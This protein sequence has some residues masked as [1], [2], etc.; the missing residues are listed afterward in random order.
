MILF[1]LL[2]TGMALV[3]HPIRAEWLRY[4]GSICMLCALVYISQRQT[5][6]TTAYFQNCQTPEVIQAK[7]L[8]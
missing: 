2:I 1:H 4:L 7:P 8:Q 6:P 3:R 5:T